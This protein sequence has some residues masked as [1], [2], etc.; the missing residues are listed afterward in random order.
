MASVSELSLTRENVTIWEPAN[1]FDSAQIGEGTSIGKF[2]EIGPNVEIGKNCRIQAFVFIPEGV[3]LE[4]NVFVGPHAVFTN[5]KYPPS[6]KTS[7]ARTLVKSG[8]AI[9]ANATILPGVVIGERAVIGAGAV[10]TKDVPA[11]A[12]VFGNPATRRGTHK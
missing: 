12:I 9:G 4:D 10:V 2:T 7:W 11:D 5:D 8:A 3:K 1:V 6:K